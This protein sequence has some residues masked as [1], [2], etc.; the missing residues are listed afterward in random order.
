MLTKTGAKLMAAAVTTG[1]NFDARPA[2][3]LFQTNPREL[4]ATSEHIFYT[5]SH[6]GQRFLINTAV[7][8]SD[9]QPMTVILNWT[10]RLNR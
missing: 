9:T 6:D 1:A 3:E 5:V 2:V 10:S 4:V 8:G 7:K